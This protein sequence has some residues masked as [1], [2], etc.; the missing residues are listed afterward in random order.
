[1]W[2]KSGE[3]G[4]AEVLAA[5]HHVSRWSLRK[6]PGRVALLDT[7]GN[8]LTHSERLGIVSVACW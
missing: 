7:Y 6:G 5:M 8:Y 3:P 1:M 4:S 2:S